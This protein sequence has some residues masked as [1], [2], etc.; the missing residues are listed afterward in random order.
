M[1]SVSEWAH[2]TAREHDDTPPNR[3]YQQPNVEDDQLWGRLAD[4]LERRLAI[5][6]RPHPVACPLE[7]VTDEL[8]YV[9]FVLHNEDH[10]RHHQSTVATCSQRRKGKVWGRRLDFVKLDVGREPREV[11]IGSQ[12]EDQRTPPFGVESTAFVVRLPDACQPSP[13]VHFCSANR[14]RRKP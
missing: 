4:F 11:R 12:N 5:V 3:Q 7:G 14:T 6:D 10:L 8:P 9:G 13:F 1:R 2:S